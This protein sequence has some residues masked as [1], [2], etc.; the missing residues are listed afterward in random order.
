[1]ILCDTEVA[2]TLKNIDL[3]LFALHYATPTKYS[4]QTRPGTESQVLTIL[5]LVRTTGWVSRLPLV[6]RTLRPRGAQA[7]VLDPDLAA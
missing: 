6:V 4:N 5:H 3:K 2:K 7:L 1:M